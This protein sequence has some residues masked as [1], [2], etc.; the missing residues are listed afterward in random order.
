M[1][2]I[3]REIED[4]LRRDNIAK[5][6]QSY[7]RYV[8]GLFILIVAATA[9]VVGWRAYEARQQR[10]ESARYA[11]ALALVQK[12]QTTQAA[13]AFTE[14]ARE[15]HGG[16]AMLA[17]M[18]AAGLRGK[19]G[20]EKAAIADYKAIADDGSVDPT[21]RD[22]ARLLAGLAEL[23]TGDAKDA[24]AELAP[25]TAAGNPFHATALEATAIADLKAGNRAAASRIYKQL[26][27]DLSAPQGLRA[28][29][30]EMNEAL[31]E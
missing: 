14:L 12:D 1:S 13:N 21:Y 9:A 15:G 17:R 18:Q 30:A 16:T 8:I 7:G 22:L 24:A 29:A 2:D 3:F 11:A 26:A 5:L 23:Q 27:D 10:A 4:E 20:D 28:R 19:A 25:L 6:W 31:A